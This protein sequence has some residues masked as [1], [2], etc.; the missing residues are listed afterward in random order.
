[1]ASHGIVMRSW[2]EAL[3]AYLSDLRRK[4]KLH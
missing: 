2:Q 1:L 4:G 3:A